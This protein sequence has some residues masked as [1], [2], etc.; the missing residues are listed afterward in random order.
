MHGT[1]DDSDAL[2]SALENV[3]YIFHVAGAV[4]AVRKRDYYIHNAEGTEHLVQAVLHHAAGIKRLVFISSQA[5]AGPADSLERPKEPIDPCCPI[6]DY[7]KSKL[8][9]E[10]SVL[11]AKNRL[12]ISIVRPPGVFGPRDTETLLL[13]KMIQTGFAIIPGIRTRYLNVIYV[14]DLARGIVD[15]AESATAENNIYFLSDG[16]QYTYPIL[17]RHIGA[18]LGKKYLAVPL[19]N[20]AGYLPAACAELVTRLRNKPSQLTRQKV[21]EG[22][23]RFW[24]CS[25]ESAAK[26]F[27]FSCHYDFPAGLAET[28][29]WYRGQGWL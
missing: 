18:A 29:A 4:K 20:F 2:F 11:R 21:R 8:L 9:A 6:S 23:Q 13:F 16:M 19:P 14:K 27:N 15:T 10:Q 25:C 12:S 1:L 3:D 22:A 7:G 5:A 28:V 26:D 24:L 17:F